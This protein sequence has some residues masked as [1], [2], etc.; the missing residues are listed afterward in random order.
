MRPEFK[1]DMLNHRKKNEKDLLCLLAVSVNLPGILQI[2]CTFLPIAGNERFGS[3]LNSPAY[4]PHQTNKQTLID[5]F[6]FVSL[7]GVNKASQVLR[8]TADTSWD[9][10]IL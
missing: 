8:N 9:T 6:L 7:F 2:P 10:I 5:C 1:Q 4:L 3:V